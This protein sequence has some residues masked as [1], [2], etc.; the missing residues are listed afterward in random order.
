MA[1][2]LCSGQRRA[3]G[4]VARFGVFAI[5]YLRLSV[6]VRTP[7]GAKSVDDLRSTGGLVGCRIVPRYGGRRRW[8]TGVSRMNER[9]GSS[10]FEKGR[11]V[12][13]R[14]M[15]VSLAVAAFIAILA[16]TGVSEERKPG[17]TATASAPAG[18]LKT[19]TGTVETTNSRKQ[20]RLV[21]GGAHYELF[22]AD[23]ADANV[24]DTLAA[25]SKGEATGTYTVKGTVS[26]A[27]GRASIQVVSI[28]KGEAGK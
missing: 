16:T 19:L 26:D 20:P 27:S 6:S 2:S 12:S 28:A 17:A 11:P 15:A 5:F 10:E 1:K 7:V 18:D 3:K 23:K 4:L 14:I 25:I 24:K 21:V 8:G 13:T 22:A 9:P